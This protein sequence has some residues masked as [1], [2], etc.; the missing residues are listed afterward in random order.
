MESTTVRKAIMLSCALALIASASTAQITLFNQASG[1]INPF[2]QTF[3]NFISVDSAVMKVGT[4]SLLRPNTP[5]NTAYIPTGWATNSGSTGFTIQ[6]WINRATA[7][8]GNADYI[9]GDNTMVSPTGSGAFR[10]FI[11]GVAGVSKMIIRGVPNQ[12]ITVGLPFAAPNTWVH[13]A[14]VYAP[15][16]PATA[17][18][19]RW[20]INGVSDPA[21]A[22]T[23]LA[24]GLSYSGTNFTICGYNGSSSVDPQFNMDEIRIYSFPRTTADIAAD[25]LLPAAGNG[26]SGASNV[27]DKVYLDCDGAVQPHICTVGI[28]ADA[29]GT[30]QR[31]MTGGTTINWNGTSSAVMTGVPASCLINIH[32]P[33]LGLPVTNPYTNALRPAAPMAVP[34]MTPG[35]AGLEM[36]HGLSIPGYPAAVIWPDGLGL[37]II[38]GLA[39]L[40]VPLPHLYNVTAPS[41]FTIPG[42]LFQHGDS[43]DMQW[44]APDPGYPSNLGISNRGT[45]VYSDPAVVNPGAHCHIEARGNGAIQ[46]ATFWEIWN[47]GLDPIVRVTIDATTCAANGGSATGFLPTGL[48]NSGGTLS[49]G[50]SYRLGTDISCGLVGNYTGIGVAGAGVAGL[51]FDFTSFEAATDVF[52]FDCDSLAVQNANGNVYIG[53]TVSVYYASAPLVP[54]IG[55]LIADPFATNAAQLDL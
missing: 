34:Y 45:F 40:V 23:G 1:V 15:A 19:L 8:T 51:Q 14:L 7:T 18:T 31:I 24:T 2:T 44:I 55:L 22:Q 13:V 21:I 17:S 4:G 20:V 29:L 11:G 30:G 38:P 52:A 41:A 10:C 16:V 43:I 47:T 36:G 12:A 25:M 27:P 46:V 49:A 39:M 42:G 33:S 48:L 9:L 26:P 53:A 50:T 37:G 54:V 32:G 3:G 6:F 35:I 28:N 5:A